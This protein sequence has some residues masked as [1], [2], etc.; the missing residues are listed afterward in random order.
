MSEA[1]A[2]PDLVGKP[3][4]GMRAPASGLYVV[5]SSATPTSAARWW[6]IADFGVLG[7]WISIVGFT[8]RYHEK[9]ADEAQAWLIAR[10]LNLK[11]IWLHELRYEGS[12][13][14]WHTILWVAQHVFHMRYEALG[15][16]GMAGA[17]AGAA[18]LIFKAPFPR[19]VRWPLAFTYFLV[20]QYAVIARPYTL[21]PLLAFAAALFF[22]DIQHP[23]RMT[24]VLV[25][26]AN[27]SLHGTILA[28]CLGLAYLI[29]A[30]RSWESLDA[31]V[32]RRYWICVGVMV[33]TFVFIG[34]ILKPTPDVG[35]FVVKKEI[36]QSPA[37]V[38]AQFPTPWRKLSTVISG[39][40]LDW[41][42]PS[43]AFVLLAGAW[44]AMRR[45]LLTF[46]LP[47]GLLIALYAAVHGYAHHHGTVF[48]A[49]IVALWIAWPSDAERTGFSVTQQRAL[50]GMVA[51]LVCL[52]A[53]NIWDAG[54]AIK[55]EYIFPY[56]G[57]ADAAQYLKT[58]G[59][60]RGP[61]FGFLFGVVAVQAYFDQNI[62]ANMPT[63]YFHQGIPFDGTSLDV[64]Q[65]HRVS[66]E[67]VVAYSNDP[68]MMLRYGAPLLVGEGY[69]LEHFSDGYYLYKRSVYQR[70]TYLVFR[71]VHPN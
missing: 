18:L 62:F 71:R 59:A 64:E 57:A 7:I 14:L 42:A 50:Q 12:P 40:F 6:R 54:V 8:L 65:L 9:W 2:V 33:L 41:L 15:F 37:E 68:R 30:I 67:Y 51:L 36:T 34:L 61:M 43:V 11:T 17:A 27:L 23:A 69:Q 60:T 21:M 10:D 35:E 28:G 47:V 39:A 48:V 66:P 45:R 20:Y 58:V 29:E 1:A 3:A 52:C 56:S 32:K 22:K 53:L 26:L 70:E 5:S 55:R 25:L 31:G 63:A 24:V 38:Q 19:Y 44:C 49:M 46:A 16:I 13:G 4:D